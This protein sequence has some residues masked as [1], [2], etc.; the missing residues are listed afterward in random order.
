MCRKSLKSKFILYLI[1]NFL[2][3]K[4]IQLLFRNKFPDA[5]DI[6]RL[7]DWYGTQL[8]G[9]VMENPCLAYTKPSRMLVMIKAN[10]T[11]GHK[12]DLTE[13]SHYW[14]GIL[15]DL[16]SKIYYI[17]TLIFEKILNYPT[18]TNVEE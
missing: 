3:H 8:P 5:E 14:K 12:Y 2:N 16:H 11:M 4:C 6:N 9:I 13:T 15:Q 7:R 17:V 18:I 1:I 10:R